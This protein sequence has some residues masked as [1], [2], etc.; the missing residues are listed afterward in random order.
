MEASSGVLDGLLSLPKG[1]GALRA[2][3]ERF[4]PD[5]LRGTG[6]YSVPISVLEGPNRIKPDLQLRYSSG[7]GNGPFGL[8]W[9]LNLLDIRRR[10]DRGVPTYTDQDEFVLGGSDVLVPVGGGR[11]RP[12]SD[13]SFWDI[14]RAGDGWVVRTKEG[15]RYTFGTTEGS[16]VSRGGRVFAWLLDTE[17][18]AA[19]N[20]I[21]YTY[22]RRGGYLYLRQINWSIYTLRFLYEERP[23][24]L[25]DGRAG[26]PIQTI[27]RCATIELRC[28]RL[29]Q[30]LLKRYTLDYDEANGSGLSLLT[31]IGL[32]GYDE[33]GESEDYFTTTLR[34]SQH[35]PEAARYMHLDGELLPSLSNP[36]TT[37][38]DMT[39]DSL[40]D[41]LQTGP[42]G[43]RFWPNRGQGTFGDVHRL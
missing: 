28:E 15:R 25:H 8:G 4:Q 35:R 36:D 5:L 11:Y 26:F 37:L 2:L 14:R 18:D 7:Q 30:P 20:E 13:T 34:Y 3:G 23:D 29:D 43:H 22:D 32:T 1:G 40:P 16:R 9:Q 41:L 38:V 19:G 10:T 27:W 6:N 33:A 12:R 24:I 42:G 39:G 31:E 21:R 17:T